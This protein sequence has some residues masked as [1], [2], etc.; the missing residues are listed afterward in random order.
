MNR[1]VA[2]INNEPIEENKNYYI[3]LLIKKKRNNNNGG[4]TYSIG[5]I[6]SLSNGKF[7]IIC[8]YYKV[9]SFI[10]NIPFDYINNIITKKFPLGVSDNI[11]NSYLNTDVSFKSIQECKNSNTLKIESIIHFC[12]KEKSN[13][14]HHTNICLKSI[15]FKDAYQFSS[16]I[17]KNLK[18]YLDLDDIFH[19]NDIF[20][21]HD[22]D[23]EYCN[24]HKII[25]GDI[26]WGVILL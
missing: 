6:V 17:S 23:I 3:N 20:N 2:G 13:K 16:N 24:I 22:D 15:L 25:N 26:A 18:K 12:E 4:A 5:C 14:I 10:N 7:K 1:I 11:L 8:R 21:L 9:Y 19:I